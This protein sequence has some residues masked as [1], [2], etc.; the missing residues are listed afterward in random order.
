MAKKSKSELAETWARNNN[1]CGENPRWDK[2]KTYYNLTVPQILKMAK[3]IEIKS[4][5]S[6]E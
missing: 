3:Y 2:G 5:V 6:E 4:R 1:I